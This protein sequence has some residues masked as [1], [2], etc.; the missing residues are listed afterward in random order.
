MEDLESFNESLFDDFNYEMTEKQFN[1]KN[2]ILVQEFQDV[3]EAQDY[4][5]VFK[6]SKKQKLDLSKISFYIIT[7]ENLKILFEK[8]NL[9]EYE[10]FYEE[11]Y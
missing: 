8:Q 1:N 2:F 3:Y 9:E 7:K 10:L 11:N 4:R 6:S 5:R